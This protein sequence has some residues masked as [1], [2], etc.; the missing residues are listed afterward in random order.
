MEC[1]SGLRAGVSFTE[2]RGGLP[3][4]WQA[5]GSSPEKLFL[6]KREIPC[7]TAGRR[8]KPGKTVTEML[9]N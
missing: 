4:C 8:V 2:R 6:K 5:G 3:A 9:V 1:F 7:L